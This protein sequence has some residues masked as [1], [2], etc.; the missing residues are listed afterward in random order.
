MSYQDDIDLWVSEM[1]TKVARL[2]QRK[3]AS[4]S[5]TKAEK[6]VQK[7][8]AE[9]VRFAEE[10]A[11]DGDRLRIR[12]RIAELKRKIAQNLLPSLEEVEKEVDHIYGDQ[13]DN[14]TYYFT[15]KQSS[16]DVPWDQLSLEEAEKEVDKTY[17]DQSKN[18]TWYF[19]KGK[20][21]AALKT[22]G[23]GYWDGGQRESY[24]DQ[25]EW[26]G[27][28]YRSIKE[29]L[30]DVLYSFVTARGATSEEEAL[31][32]LE[33]GPDSI[34]HEMDAYWDL[35]LRDVEEL[36]CNW[37]SYAKDV[38]RKLQV[39]MASEKESFGGAGEYKDDFTQHEEMLLEDD[40]WGSIHDSYRRDFEQVYDT[41]RDPEAQDVPEYFENRNY[42]EY[43]NR[44]AMMPPGGE[45]GYFTNDENMNWE[46]QV[47]VDVVHRPDVDTP[48]YWGDEVD[49]F[50]H[51]REDNPKVGR[52][53]FAARVPHKIRG[54]KYVGENMA[55]DS[56][57]KA[58]HL[59]ENSDGHQVFIMERLGDELAVMQRAVGTHA[60][61][62]VEDYLESEDDAID[63]AVRFMNKF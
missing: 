3:V 10:S 15:R 1:E 19:N 11:S 61:G 33:E 24:R 41:N 40:E 59:W 16:S 9:L 48:Q 53:R 62:I 39:R 44:E 49:E 31:S 37:R 54:F 63:E 18:D 51:V 30:V 28:S 29:K 27:T 57:T 46:E 36:R 4:S 47:D 35:E 26:E 2:R 23:R 7:K 13:S 6:R 56:R 43:A 5:E 52:N 12:E 14:S 17:G 22:A 8:I 20:A 32:H 21:T 25:I 60:N 38:R 45:K 42:Q 34:I 58:L 55:L 50:P